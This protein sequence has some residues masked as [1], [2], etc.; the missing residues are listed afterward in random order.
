[1]NGGGGG[2]QVYV[3]GKHDL[4]TTRAMGIAL[5]RQGRHRNLS[6]VATYAPIS[7]PGTKNDDRQA[8]YEELRR[9]CHKCRG[10]D[11]L[12][13]IG[14]DMNAEPGRPTDDNEGRIIGANGATRR[15]QTG[16]ELIQFC[17]EEGL[18]IVSTCFYRQSRARGGTQG[19]APRTS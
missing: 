17:K 14:G 19:I 12:L 6:L 5:P 15:S 11:N 3:S 16:D 18:Y 1:M 8:Y 7:G 2:A 9:V 10:K 13:V 4:A